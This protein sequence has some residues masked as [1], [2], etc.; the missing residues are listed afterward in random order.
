VSAAFHYWIF[1]RAYADKLRELAKPITG[2]E[3][4]K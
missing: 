4:R 2:K 1:D 3:R